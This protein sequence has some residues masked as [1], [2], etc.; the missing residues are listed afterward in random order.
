M[1]NASTRKTGA[2]A[3][4][5]DAIDNNAVSYDDIVARL[6]AAMA[7]QAGDADRLAE[8]VRA[9]L[10]LLAAGNTLF[11]T[12]RKE[13][14]SWLTP[15]LLL[16][17]V[18]RC[19]SGLRKTVVM[20]RFG[21]LP[22]DASAFAQY[23]G[24]PSLAIYDNPVRIVED[25]GRDY[26]YLAAAGF[27]R[28]ED[29]DEFFS[30]KQAIVDAIA[31][32]AGRP[33]PAWLTAIED[34]RAAIRQTY[35]R[36]R[37]DPA[38]LAYPVTRSSH[39]HMGPILHIIARLLA[40]GAAPLQ[41]IGGHL[42][43]VRAMGFSTLML[44][45]VDRQSTNVHYGEHESGQ[46]FTYVNNHGYWCSGETGIDPALGTE[47]DYSRLARDAAAGGLLIMQD[48]VLASLGYPV[49]VARLAPGDRS[50][51][52]TSVVVGTREVSICDHDVFLHQACIP[53]ED[54]LGGDVCPDLYADVLSRA[55]CGTL[56]A[57][58]KP[59]L[60]SPQVLDA[61]LARARWQIRAAGISAFRIDMAKHIGSAQLRAIIAALRGQCGDPGR[62]RVLLEYLTIRYRDVKFA[63][64]SLEEQAE[65]VYLYD[66][67]LAQ[68]LKQILVEDGDVMDT[69]GELIAE[70]EHWNVSPYQLIPTFIDHDSSFQPIYNGDEA[71]RATVVAG[72]VIAAMLSANAMYVYFGF[73]KVESGADGDDISRAMVSEI[74]ASDPR[75]PA[76]A[77]KQLFSAL[78]ATPALACWQDGCLAIAGD[79]FS[80][81]ITRTMVDA[82]R[83]VT[84]VIEAL[85][86]RFHAPAPAPDG[87]WSLIFSHC[88]GPSVHIRKK[89]T[90]HE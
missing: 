20:V 12:A 58:P 7:G 39:P 72:Y 79:M 69:L 66:F 14:D 10:A 44:G 3:I 90:P 71:S 48:T 29:L 85:F 87:D 84:T 17:R 5:S 74:F 11:S 56:Y 43:A 28:D 21:E 50:N 9:L 32:G 52:T 13:C 62:F 78:A 46:L 23:H 67:P 2:A 81:T 1:L 57:L 15:T 41:L 47:D 60:F 38:A 22:A 26:P 31:A 88:H 45:C 27:M 82:A 65:C 18:A 36:V 16:E 53:E 49:Q 75:S 89:E 34:D 25:E 51:P 55:H 33:A 86:S 8:A 4:F 35:E 83:G 76:A 77:L 68:A 54:S 73:D 40:G 30:N 61:S 42:A 6:G 59:N 70:R 80:A 24:E 64:A 63:I 37:K 19:A